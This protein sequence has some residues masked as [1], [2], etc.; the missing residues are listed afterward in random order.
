MKIFC[1]KCKEW[2]EPDSEISA[3]L[4]KAREA[5]ARLLMIKCPLCGKTA[6][7]S[8]QTLALPEVV[9][10]EKFR[11][12]IKMCA[13]YAVYVSEDGGF[14]GC[15]ECGNVWRNSRDLFNE[16]RGII[17][18]YPHRKSVYREVGDK[19]SPIYSEP[20]DYEDMVS[21]ES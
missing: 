13:G 19:Y 11:C 1:D 15:G 18:K 3:S 9:E 21:S 6:P 17:K 7:V 14:W 8:P 16:I 4:Q 2:Y 10:N 20:D 5:G 12:P